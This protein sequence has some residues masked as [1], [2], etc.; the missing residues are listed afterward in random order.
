MQ[1]ATYR[2]SAYLC[3]M[4][5]IWQGTLRSVLW[6]WMVDHILLL[7][8]SLLHRYQI[9]LLGDIG[10]WVWTICPW[11]L[12]SNA[13][14]QNTDLLIVSVMPHHPHQRFRLSY[15][16]PDALSKKKTYFIG[17]K[18]ITLQR[19]WWSRML[20]AQHRFRWKKWSLMV[21]CHGIF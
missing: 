17:G 16:L 15:W 12:C 8:S 4:L 11:L 10:T 20:I 19:T 14:S 13:Q 9:V 1:S 2:C 21:V 6:I 18:V 3:F 7:P 5:L